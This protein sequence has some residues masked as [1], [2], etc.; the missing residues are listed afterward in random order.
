MEGAGLNQN[1]K[2]DGSMKM[3]AEHD[4]NPQ[5]NAARPLKHDGRKDDTLSRKGAAE[6]ARWLQAY[7]TQKDTSPR[8]SGR[9]R[10]RSDW[11]SSGLMEC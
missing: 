6:L 3:I 4:D 5:P 11:A 9:S 1:K 7:G 2:G 8:G 10:S